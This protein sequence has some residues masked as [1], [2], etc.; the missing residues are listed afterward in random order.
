MSAKNYKFDLVIEGEFI[1]LRQ[2]RLSDAKDIFRWR[3]SSSGKYLH[4]PPDYSVESQENWIR[5]LSDDVIY[6]IIYPKNS[7]E[8]VGMVGIYEV[9]WIDSIADCGGLILDE[10]YIEHGSPY[11]LE[12]L[13]LCYEYIYTK[14]GI[15]K[16]TGV[17]CGL[18]TRVISLQTHLGM[19]QE[20]LLKKHALIDGN[21]EDLCIFS[22]FKEDFPNYKD[23]INKLL[24]K[25]RK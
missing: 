15:R 21:Y 14:M 2:V 11:G 13:L 12:A 23:N 19:T 8:S 25:Y 6:Y 24:N 17:I 10:K 1:D 9:N 4:H 5:N 18:N 16:T 3:S 20:G 7:T 22:L